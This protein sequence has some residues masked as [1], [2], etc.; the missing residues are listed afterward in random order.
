MPINTIVSKAPTIINI[1]PAN[2]NVTPVPPIPTSL[3]TAFSMLNPLL[4]LSRPTIPIMT[5]ISISITNK[6]MVP[7]IPVI[8]PTKEPEKTEPKI[9]DVNITTLP[10]PTNRAAPISNNT[11]LLTDL[12]PSSSVCPL[13]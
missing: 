1:Y 10:I 6:S 3:P 12:I 4:I 5:P 8:A 11:P 13:I 2:N 7:A 9:P